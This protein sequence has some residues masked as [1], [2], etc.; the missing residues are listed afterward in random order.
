MTPGSPKPRNNGQVAPAE[1]HDQQPVF[2]LPSWTYTSQRFFE[3]EQERL[4]RHSWQ[5][6]CH[7]SDVPRPGDYFIFEFLREPIVVVRGADDVIRGFYNVCR[8]RAARLLDGS[9][10]TPRGHCREFIRCPYHAWTYGLSGK[11]LTLPHE[12]SY[13]GLNKDDWGLKSVSVEIWQGFIFVNLEPGQGP[14]VADMMAP[15][16][17]DLLCYRFEE[18]RALGRI[19]LRRRDVNWKT[20]TDNYV[21]GLHIN[22]A[23]TGLKNIAGRSY[24]LEVGEHVSVMSAQLEAVTRSSWS[25]RMY[26]DIKP[27][28]DHLPAQRQNFWTYFMVWPNLAFD[29]YPD[30]VDFMQM[31]PLSPGRTLIREITY[32]LPDQRREMRIARYLNWRINRVVNLEDKGLVERV[33]Q[34]MASESFVRGPLSNDE[35][36]LRSFAERLRQ[37]LPE[38]RKPEEPE[39]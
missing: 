30:Q 23:H 34:G 39:T 12:N 26:L 25:E 3:L 22:V 9:A 5:V 24:G 20:V 11:L 29:V 6:V 18:L 16:E 15:Y 38:C 17:D 21:D 8:H 7:Q 19:T 2:G 10:S 27:D 28:C 35:I 33:Q 31:I 1:T 32:A 14:S 4:F 13:E 37:V 36:C